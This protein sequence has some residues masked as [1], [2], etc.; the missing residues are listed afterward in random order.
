M[1]EYC[2]VIYG[3][4]LFG[5]EAVFVFSSPEAADSFILF[6]QEKLLQEHIRDL[7]GI[8]LFFDLQVKSANI[9]KYRFISL[10]NCFSRQSVIGI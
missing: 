9:G 7:K 10:I 8:A 5:S 6:L 4:W 1:K 3:D 2:V